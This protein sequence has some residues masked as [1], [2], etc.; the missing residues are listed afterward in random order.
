M[1]QWKRNAVRLISVTID[2]F[3]NLRDLTIDFD[4][5]SPYT[6]VIGENGAGKSN[7]IEALAI[8]FRDL[9][10]EAPSTL[11]YK[12]TYECRGNYVRIASQANS[13]PKFWLF[14]DSN[15]IYRSIPRK[16]YMKTDPEGQPVYRPAFVFGYYSGPSDRLAE[17]FE[18]HEERFYKEIIKAPSSRRGLAAIDPNLL[19]RLFYARTLQGQFALLAFFTSRDELASD[20]RDFLR[21]EL[22]IAGLDSVLFVFRDPPWDGKGGDPRFWNAEGEVQQFLDLLYREAF[23]PM[24]MERR[25]QLDLTRNPSVECLY[26]FLPDQQ[27]L[28]EVYAAYGDQYAFFT[29]LES[30][31]LSK[32]LVEVRARVRLTAY[33]GGNKVTYRDLSEGEQQ[34]LLVLGL[35]KFTARDEALFLLDEPDTHLNPIWSTQYLKFLDR[36]IRRRDQQSCHILMTTHDP[37]VFAG[38]HRPQVQIFTR[39]S[40]GRVQVAIPEEDPQGMGVNAILTSDLFRL[41]STLDEPTQ[42]D[43]DRV[44]LLSM[45]EPSGAEAEELRAISGRLHGKGLMAGTRDPLYTLFARAWTQRENPAWRDMTAFTTDELAARERLAAEIV[46]ELAAE[47]ASGA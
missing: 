20:D 24:R 43:L 18:R 1:Q 25:L 39:D 21:D 45:R 28:E 6:V 10:L 41:R 13:R 16:R 22:Q 27:A 36:F 38:L 33:A 19:R 11:G 9:D 31:H 17:V 35:L 37:L 47:E 4:A 2:E 3:K 42:A 40:S 15:D 12:L 7:L 44:R 23:Y 26:L 30:T 29:A 14:D 32:L 34:L 8:I 46:A 5:T